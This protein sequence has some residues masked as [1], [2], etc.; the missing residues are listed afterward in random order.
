MP[1]CNLFGDGMKVLWWHG[2][3]DSPGLRF[4]GP[5]SLLRKEGLKKG[6]YKFTK[7]F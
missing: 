7:T 5:P 6:I 1:V 3:V 2:G 4:A